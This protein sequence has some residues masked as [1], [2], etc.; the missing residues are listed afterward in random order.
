MSGGLRYAASTLLFCHCEYLHY[1]IASASEAIA[2]Y[3][4]TGKIAS[5]LSLLAMTCTA[6]YLQYAVLQMLLN[7]YITMEVM[8]KMETWEIRNGMR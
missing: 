3:R 7:C 6:M 5:S 8:L 1:I 4:N 2:L